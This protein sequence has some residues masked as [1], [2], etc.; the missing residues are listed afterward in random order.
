MTISFHC[1]HCGRKIE[2]PDDAGGKWGKCP[3]CHNKVYIPN[4]NVDPN[5]KLAPVDEDEEKRQREL[6][7]ETHKLT[8]NILQQ[9]DVPNEGEVSEEP[10]PEL[11][12]EQLKK[13]ITGYLRQ[14]ADG[15]L[16]EAQS[17]LR[18]ITGQGGRALKMVDKMAVSEVP[19][20]ELSDIP[21]RVLSG[22]IKDLRSKLV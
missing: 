9:R 4:L 5:I 18:K 13:E 15:E 20:D 6:L 1:E 3:A 12:D 10:V 22:L 19:E 17:R 21:P 16:S 11:N 2:A 14:M 7:E 8:Q